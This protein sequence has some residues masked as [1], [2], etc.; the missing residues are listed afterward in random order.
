MNPLQMSSNLPSG[1]EERQ[2]EHGRVYYIDH[3][4]QTTT[5]N[6]PVQTYPAVVTAFPVVTTGPLKHSWVTGLCCIS[7]SL[8]HF[9]SILCDMII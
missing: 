7:L 5:W 6:R 4:T 2:D 9:L 3:N 1:W 8:F